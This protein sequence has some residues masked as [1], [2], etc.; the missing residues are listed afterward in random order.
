MRRE[1]ATDC[2]IPKGDIMTFFSTNSPR[3]HRPRRIVTSSL[4]AGVLAIGWFVALSGFSH[5]IEHHVI[6]SSAPHRTTGCETGNCQPFTKAY[7]HHRT[8]WRRWP[9]A[10][11]YQGVLKPKANFAI[12]ADKVPEPREEIRFEPRTRSDRPLDPEP[13]EEMPGEVVPGAGSEMDPNNPFQVVPESDLPPEQNGA[14]SDLPPLT[15]GDDTP[16]NEPPL[17]Q[18]PPMPAESTS[19][20]SDNTPDDA[21]LD[22]F[23]L[24]KADAAP[25]NSGG[26]FDAPTDPQTTPSTL[27]GTDNGLDALPPSGLDDL[28]PTGNDG[29]QFDGDNP[30]GSR[31]RRESDRPRVAN[32]EDLELIQRQQP[33]RDNLVSAQSESDRPMKE[34]IVEQLTVDPIPSVMGSAV[35]VPKFET[36]GNFTGEFSTADLVSPANATAALTQT[37]TKSQTPTIT[38]EQEALRRQ[39]E[40]LREQLEQSGITGRSKPAPRPNRPVSKSQ[41]AAGKQVR[42]QPK[43]PISTTKSAQAAPAKAREVVYE[44]TGN[45][46]RPRRRYLDSAQQRAVPTIKPV[47]QQ[48]QRELTTNNSRRGGN[49]TPRIERSV[50]P[51]QPPAKKPQTS[52]RIT[53]ANNSTASQRFIRTGTSSKQLPNILN[54]KRREQQR[55]RELEAL[56]ARAASS[57][58]A[59]IKRVEQASTVKIKT[60]TKGG[61]KKPVNAA[62]PST[63][64]APSQR[65]IDP[66]RDIAASNR[67]SL[68]DTLRTNPLRR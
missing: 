21:G 18:A 34:L 31:L 28:P 51:I 24:P 37:A 16:S 48:G 65:T 30:F 8:H 7:G 54:T 58:P 29:F 66:K 32:G 23:G 19:P 52:R 5:G 41:Q 20:T 39:I 17:G 49:V 62:S 35:D 42:A 22:I 4:A 36:L 47:M 2:S 3:S 11:E 57:A 15:D 13:V 33:R 45:P 26:G 25:A 53:T 50:H 68:R 40:E 1:K 55:Q 59:Q 9:T 56:R 6:S 61:L 12:P 14:Q 67:R 46:L 60:A 43:R 44:D 10:K 38:A 63:A 64:S 27:P